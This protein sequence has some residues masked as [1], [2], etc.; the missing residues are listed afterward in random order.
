MWI[1]AGGAF[2]ITGFN[3][4]LWL[5]TFTKR[6]LSPLA[7]AYFWWSF[8]I[9]LWSFGYGVTL[10]GIFDYNTTLW[11]NKYCQA[12]ATLISP[13]FFRFGACVANQFDRYRKLYQFYLGLATVNALALFLT[14]YYVKGLWSFGPYPYQPLGGP[15][16]IVFTAL[17]FWCTVH[18]FLVA[19]QA[20]RNVTGRKKKQVSLFLLGT[21]IAYS[22]GGTL[23]LQGY[24]I[25]FPTHGVYLILGYVIVI[26]YAIHRYRFLDL[27][28][29]IRKTVVFAGLFGSIIFL[30]WIVTTLFQ[31]VLGPKLGLGEKTSLM[32]GIL[33]WL[34]LYD[35]IQRFLMLA[36]DRFL[37]QKKV[38]IRE[39]L[40]RLS[41]RIITILNLDQV[42]KMILETFRDSLH[43][44]TGALLLKNEADYR[45]LNSFG[46]AGKEGRGSYAT[47]DPLIRYFCSHPEVID[48]ESEE[49]YG[50]LPLPISGALQ[51]LG[52]V[53]AIPLVLQGELIG[54]LTLGKKKSDEEYAKEEMD[55]FP[56]VASQVAIALSN[57]RLYGE[58][59]E[60]RK[61]IEAMQIELIHR[62]KMAFVADLVK[63]IA[64]EVFNPLLPV[65]HKIEEIERDI[66]VGLYRIL[67]SEGERLSPA[68]R[69]DYFKLLKDLNS[70]AQTLKVNSEHIHLV[71]D[72]LNK[73]QKEDEE[74]IGP[75]DFKMF[76]KD[77]RALIGM[78]LHSEDR[79]IPVIE[80]IQRRLPP[81]KGNPTLLK[82]V[83]INL[84]KNAIHAMQG[85]PEKK[86]TIKADIDPADPRFLK[87]DF[88]DTGP[89][90]P[91]DILPRIFE[92]GFTTKGKKGQGI[93][94]AQSRLIIEKFGGTINCL[95]EPGQGAVF[96]LCLPLWKE[97]EKNAQDLNRR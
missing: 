11:W 51:K 66:L 91:A 12:I 24:G 30:L 3:I 63:G 54:L 65:Y 1:D 79:E 40:K 18:S 8:W 17:F 72:T 64:H 45:V 26:G 19:A 21:G 53:V 46:L 69:E 9:T 59:V 75:L 67:K 62:E 27:P 41:E 83:F 34:L 2:A 48:L 44:E 84:F 49:T 13:F 96:T 47:E 61:K 56:T 39:I 6:R 22:G 77:S 52:V 76:L 82:Q 7:K 78:E 32:A 71:I 92:F 94:L 38:P 10:S 31:A 43:L 23:F 4:T 20:Y 68:A 88:S 37:F 57:A 15:L 42:A 29:L 85:K 60:A 36:T 70:A 35:P 95:S 14:P 80:D 55:Y 86:I 87:I 58:A 25:P 28:S 90:I 73:M 81:L 74:T 16:Y 93:G 97:E 5:L 33:I 50:R 89:G